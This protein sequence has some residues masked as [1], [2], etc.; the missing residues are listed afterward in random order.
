MPYAL[1]IDIR[2]GST[3]AAVA[4]L[5]RDR[6]EPP[7][8]VLAIPSAL[9]LTADGPVAG[10]PGHGPDI[11]R[12]FV[13]RIGDEVPLV[14]GGRPYR[15]ANLAAELIDQVVRRVEAAEGGPA[16]QLAV[17]IPEPWGPYRTGLLSDAL[18]QVGLDA[19]LVPVAADG[20]GAAGA[21]QRLIAP[22][23]AVATYRPAPEESP[24]AAEEPAYPPP[25]PPVVI[26]AL[27]SPRKRATGRR[28]P[29]RVVIAAVAV[30]VIALGV[31]LTLMSGFVRL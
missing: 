14:V 11:V 4:R 29:A 2:A 24:D 18:A 10:V 15:A 9:A 17:A 26:T 13:E 28:P 23:D 16:R 5:Y 30:L 20:Q 12:G 19:T 8:V 7:E 3:E 21:V 22:P 6:W 27:T 1:G 25:R 31:W